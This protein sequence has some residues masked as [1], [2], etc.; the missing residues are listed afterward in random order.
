MLQ[1]GIVLRTHISGSKCTIFD[2]QIGKIDAFIK[3]AHKAKRA[4]NLFPGALIYYAREDWRTQYKISDIELVSA[5]ALWAQQDLLFVHHV[6]ELC[7]FFLPL[8]CNAVELYDLLMGLYQPQ[9]LSYKKFMC[10]FFQ[11]LGIYPEQPAQFDHAFLE[12]IFLTPLDMTS[13]LIDSKIEK[14]LQQWLHECIYTHAQANQL[15]TVHFLK[16]IN[17]YE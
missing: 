13:Q 15:K 1:Q 10:R 17:E 8:H 9:K 4:Q 7:M 12:Y 3:H 14:S 2:K 11:R 6:I 5:P 16:K